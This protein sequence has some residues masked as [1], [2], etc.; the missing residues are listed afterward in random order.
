MLKSRGP[1]AALLA[2]ALALPAAAQELPFS[3][4]PLACPAPAVD[5]GPNAWSPGPAAKHPPAEP[6]VDTG[7]RGCFESDQAFPGFVGPISNPFLSKDPRSLTEVRLVFI[8]DEIPSTHP[9]GGGSFQA[10]GVQARVALTD[11]LT[12]IADKD[13]YAW[14]HPGNGGEDDGF[15]NVAAGLKYLLVRDVPHQFLWSVGAQY[16]PQTGEGKVF[17]SQGDGV[18]S[19]WTTMGKQFCDRWH[20]IG[21]AGYQFPMESSQNSSF[22][23]TSVH[24]DRCFFNWLYPLAELNW[25]HYNQGGDRGIP[26]AFG[27]GDGLLNIGTSGVGGNDLVT[28]AVGLKAAISCHLDTGAVFE[29]PLTGRKDLI[30]NRVIFEVIVRY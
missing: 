4:P 6:P 22:Y 29:F 18:L 14:I 10:I 17:Q 7:L 3:T 28:G 5:D 11:R 24:L 19:A 1:L 15:L 16:E 8:N 12:F 25:F 20:V 9:L 26:P 23:Y 27:E 13:G 2:G 21:T 30:D